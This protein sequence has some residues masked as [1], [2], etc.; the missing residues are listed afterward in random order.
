MKS[1]ALLSTIVLLMLSACAA[2]GN[3]LVGNQAPGQEQPKDRQFARACHDK[4]CI[5]KVK[6]TNCVVE[7]DPY[8]IVMTHRD[9]VTMEWQISGGGTFAPDAIR[10]KEKAAARVFSGSKGDGKSVAVMNNRTA[11]GIFHYGVTVK[12]GGKTCPELDPTGI[13]DMP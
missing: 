11:Y 7:V 8:F 12:D 13:N 2:T 10:W 1:R 5:I 6:V 4:R 3:W 9:P